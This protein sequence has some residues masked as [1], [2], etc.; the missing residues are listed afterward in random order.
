MHTNDDEADDQLICHTE[1]QVKFFRSIKFNIIIVK[2]GWVISFDNALTGMSMDCANDKSI[3]VQVIS[4]YRQAV[5]HYL[6]QYWRTSMTRYGVTGLQCVKDIVKTFDDIVG[7]SAA[8][9]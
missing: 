5:R 1:N 4:W 9:E 8:I 2:V 6:I 7:L 3:L